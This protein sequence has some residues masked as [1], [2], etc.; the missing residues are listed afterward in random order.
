MLQNMNI[1]VLRLLLKFTSRIARDMYQTI[2]ET[3][4]ICRPVTRQGRKDAYNLN[5]K[6]LTHLFES[7]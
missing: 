2:H 1:L 4:S 3:R 6:M 5:E 7:A